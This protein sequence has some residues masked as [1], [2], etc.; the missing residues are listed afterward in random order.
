MEKSGETYIVCFMFFKRKVHYF[1]LTYIDTFSSGIIHA[2][3]SSEVSLSTNEF[4]FLLNCLGFFSGF[5]L[6]FVLPSVLDLHKEDE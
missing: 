2:I 6:N 1:I 5:V 3:G 4:S